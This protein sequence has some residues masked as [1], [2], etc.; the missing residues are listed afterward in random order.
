MPSRCS[1]AED[2]CRNGETGKKKATSV[3]T[4]VLHSSIL[5]LLSK[6]IIHRRKEAY[7]GAGCHIRAKKK[8]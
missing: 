4:D 3:Q 8:S 1:G 7:D 6:G 2:I 5:A